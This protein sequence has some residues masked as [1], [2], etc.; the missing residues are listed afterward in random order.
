MRVKIC[1][2]TQPQQGK[3]I[4]SFGATALGFICVPTSPRYINIEQIRAVVEQLP[5]KI[6]KIGVFANTS[7]PEITQTVVHSGLTGV[8]LHGDES[9]EFCQQLR[10]LLPDIEIIKALRIRSFEDTEKAETYTSN[11]D[12]LLLDAYHPQQLGGTGTTLDWTML[13]QFRPSCPWFLAGGLTPENIIQALTQIT[14]SGIDL[15][16]GVERAPGDKD[17]D[18]VAKLFEKL[19]SKC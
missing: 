18:K 2:I 12:T 6:D 14:P 16:S 9:P 4:A 13:Q 8:Q 11:A 3:A 10:Q 19:H 7:V 17:L 5:E 15:S 1:G